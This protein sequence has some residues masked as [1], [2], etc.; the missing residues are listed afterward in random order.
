MIPAFKLK[1][2]SQRDNKKIGHI[3]PGAQCGYTSLAVCLSSIHP[4]ANSDDF[5]AQMVDEM[6]PK[7]GKPGWAEKFFQKNGWKGGWIYSQVFGGKARAG[8]YFSV[9]YEYA[10]DFIKEHNYNV[11]VELVETGGK[12]EDVIG[13]LK[14]GYPVML[15]TRILPSGHFIV[16]IEYDIDKDEFTAL[17]SWGNA[18]NGYKTR[19]MKNKYSREFLIKNAPDS[20]GTKNTCRY[21][22][23]K[24]K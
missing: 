1:P 17:D 6:E 18:I 9:Y 21:L 3:S 10:K 16:L 11:E 12:W 19:E 15:G 13:H 24:Q 20:K 4:E 2:N 23:L 22:V 7:V 14:K 8:A 5:I